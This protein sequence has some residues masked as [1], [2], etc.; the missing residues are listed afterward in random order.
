M[1]LFGRTPDPSRGNSAFTHH[2]R[3]LAAGILL[4]TWCAAVPWARADGATIAFRAATSAANAG[5]STLVLDRPAGSVAG[6][7]L[8][9]SVD[10]L[11][12]PTI[13][14]PAGWTVARSSANGTAMKQVMYYRFVG[15][16]EP[17]N[18][19]WAFSRGT[20]AAGAISA[21]VGVASKGPI[22][23]ASAASTTSSTS[24][25]APSIDVTVDGVMLVAAFGTR[26][27]TTISPPSEM[28][29]RSD[30]ASTAARG[31]SSE[32]SDVLQPQMGA[33]GDKIATSGSPNVGIAQL[34]GL[35]PQA[36]PVPNTPPT[37]T[38]STWRT[39]SD[40][41]VAATLRATDAEQCQLT[42]VIVTSPAHGS[43]GTTMGAHP[44]KAATS[45]VPNVDTATV[46]YQPNPGFVGTDSFTFQAFDGTATSNVGTVMIT[47][48]LLPP[49]VASVAETQQPVG[50]LDI[51]DDPAIWVHP[52]DPAQSVIVA[53]SKSPTEGSL[54]LYDL[55]GI[56]LQR[57]TGGK[58]N[59]VDLRYGL[60]FASSETDVVTASNKATNAIDIFTLD[61]ETSRI[62]PAGSISVATPGIEGLCMYR[63]SSTGRYYAFSIH[64]SGVVKQFEL[65]DG[66]SSA[67][68]GAL[69]RTFDVGG[70]SEGCVADDELGSIYVSEETVGLWRYGAE[71]DD[72]TS[73][74]LVD[75]IAGATRLV[76]DVEGVG[77]YH[78]GETGGYLVV[79]SQGDSTYAVYERQ[80]PH[81]FLGSFRVVD[82]AGADGAQE[83][84][85]LEVSNVSLGSSFPTGLLIAHDHN[86]VGGT[87][88]NFKLVRWGDIASALGLVVDA[89]YDPRA[90]SIDAA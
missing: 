82:G 13:T 89:S 57:V 53:T 72:A 77:I 40:A 19:T 73:P 37:A 29:E 43:L 35:R 67:I 85:G 78:V 39:F 75:G 12:A 64:P 74:V 55:D 61:A 5:G 49:G 90:S 46:R 76:P 54:Y 87:A 47:V 36:P 56:E 24:L 71:P 23:A 31:V 88:S 10:V 38:G 51:A 28:T 14:K 44:C 16:S 50:S 66:G 84:D 32:L 83:T 7:V 34:I 27:A 18:Y 42:F 30:V 6:D 58:Y 26:G 41:S 70:Q 60:P 63:S 1:L 45:T 68:T 33:T 62:A 25:R 86:N 9:A 4:L 48:K 81:A 8:V 52:T 59:N 2:A 11:G 20:P 21:Y 22:V 69:V 65:Q 80:E 79:S 15:A 3:P 17:L